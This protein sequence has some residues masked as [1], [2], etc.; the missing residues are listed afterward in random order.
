MRN[1]V[2]EPHS[3]AFRGSLTDKQQNSHFSTLFSLQNR[4][5][6]FSAELLD[7]FL[8]YF[9]PEIKQG[10]FYLRQEGRSVSKLLKAPFRRRC[11]S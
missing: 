5:F 1:H 8:H 4:L 2:T 7:Y 9:C 11:L 3:M 10:L 6:I